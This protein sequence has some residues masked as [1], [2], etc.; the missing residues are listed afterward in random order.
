MTEVTHSYP[1]LV[2]GEGQPIA[3]GRID[4]RLLAHFS[5]PP[6]QL[7]P[8]LVCRNR[9]EGSRPHRN[10]PL[11]SLQPVPVPRRAGTLERTALLRRA[12]SR[13]TDGPD[14]AARDTPVHPQPSSRRPAAGTHNPLS[15]VSEEPVALGYG[16]DLQRRPDASYLHPGPR[17][18]FANTSIRDSC[19]SPWRAFILSEFSGPQ[20]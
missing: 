19:S 10:P 3:P 2:G 11:L 6:A 1:Q 14:C 16:C 17:S 12:R 4:P 5:F 7:D 9:G 20:A 8:P 15:L 13:T 18:L